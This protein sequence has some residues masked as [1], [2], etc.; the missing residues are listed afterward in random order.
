M[1]PPQSNERTGMQKPPALDKQR[2]HQDLLEY[3]QRWPLEAAVAAL[4]H[5]LLEDR[6]D[7]Y[8]RSRL[9]GHFTA[10]SWLVDRSGTRTLLTHH[11]KLQRWLQLGGHADGDRDLAAVALREAQEESGLTGLQVERALF[12]LDRHWIPERGEVPG[13]WH[14]D[15]RFVVHAADDENYV[16]GE[17]SLDLAWRDIADMDNAES[18]GHDGDTCD[19]A[20]QRMARK[21]LQRTAAHTQ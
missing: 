9:A 10:S 6:C 14:Y 3:V 1:P 11:R 7:P 18:G 8:S 5:A 17:E 2:L 19:P 16:V 15:A 13:H 20:L 4:F 12:D 21:W